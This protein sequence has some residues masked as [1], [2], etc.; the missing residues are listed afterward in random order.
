MKIFGNQA[1]VGSIEAKKIKNEWVAFTDNGRT[2]TNKNVLEWIKRLQDE[3]IGEIVLTSVDFEGTQKGFDL[4]L[5]I[6]SIVS[7]PLILSGGI[8]SVNDI[9]NIFNISCSS[10][11][12]ISYSS[13]QYLKQEK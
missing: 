10:G 3:G 2:N 6:N 1:I 8:G 13:L 7:V 12:T 5:F 11:V 4:D 9:K